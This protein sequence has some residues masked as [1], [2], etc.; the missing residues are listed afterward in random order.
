LHEAFDVPAIFNDPCADVLLKSSDNV[1][2]RVH[3]VFLTVG[4]THF[5]KLF[6]RQPP[7]SDD[8]TGGTPIPWEEPA[9]TV[10]GLLY[11]L[12]P[13]VKPDI[14]DI[15]ELIRLAIAADKW[16]MESVLADVQTL[17]LKACFLDLRPLAVYGVACR[18]SLHETKRCAA[19]RLVELFDPFDPILRPD[20]IHL[21]APDFIALYELRKKRIAYCHQVLERHLPVY[22]SHRC[23]VGYS[24]A[25][26]QTR[27]SQYPSALILASVP[28]T[29]PTTI[30]LHDRSGCNNRECRNHWAKLHDVKKDLADASRFIGDEPYL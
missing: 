9:A 10:T 13:I 15:D 20:T 12:Y 18:L 6:L 11:R 1:F 30:E 8:T 14:D 22:F 25:A 23:Q 19:R 16:S 29:L 17:L 21:S 2:F 27:L 24:Y 3:K 4:S 26:L 5:K 7:N 28:N